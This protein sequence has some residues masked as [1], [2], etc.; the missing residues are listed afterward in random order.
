M[1]KSIF[2]FYFM[3]TN[4]KSSIEQVLAYRL[5]Y[6]RLDHRLLICLELE[7]M[8]FPYQDPEVG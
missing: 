1:I 3:F 4:Q 8:S 7:R 2:F 5:E 6:P